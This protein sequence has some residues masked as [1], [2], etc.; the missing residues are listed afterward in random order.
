MLYTVKFYFLGD[1]YVISEHTDKEEA[2]QVLAEVKE[3]RKS[4]FVDVSKK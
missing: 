4:A 1:V 2:E 3:S